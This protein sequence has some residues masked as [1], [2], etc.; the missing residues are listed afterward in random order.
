MAYFYKPINILQNVFR[1]MQHLW[2][3]PECVMLVLKKIIT[4]DKYMGEL[5]NITQW[6]LQRRTFP[7]TDFYFRLSLPGNPGKFY[8]N[9]SPMT[10]KESKPLPP[11][12]VGILNFRKNCYIQWKKKMSEGLYN[13]QSWFHSNWQTLREYL[14]DPSRLLP[15]WPYFEHASSG[16]FQTQS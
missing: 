15:D 9:S 11:W 7:G 10:A 14:S 12:Q 5:I 16:R 3:F 8:L 1:E 2:V 13:K 4:I 6:P